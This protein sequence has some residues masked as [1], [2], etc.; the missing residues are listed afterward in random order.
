M[1]ETAVIPLAAR[2]NHEEFFQGL[3]RVSVFSGFDFWVKVSLERVSSIWT[4]R[5]ALLPLR[6]LEIVK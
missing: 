2:R 3:E 6:L 4:K 1:G 5:E